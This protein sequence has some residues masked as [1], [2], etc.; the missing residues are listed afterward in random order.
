MKLVYS[1]QTESVS[2]FVRGGTIRG[3]FLE[4]QAMT[5]NIKGNESSQHCLF[6]V[7]VVKCAK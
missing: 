3:F 2:C 5:L 6:V 4:T 1:L 7:A